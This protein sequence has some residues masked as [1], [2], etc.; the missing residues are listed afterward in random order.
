MA[1]VANIANLGANYRLREIGLKKQ[2]TETDS[3]AFA[4]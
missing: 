4:P 1:S 2:L 3:L